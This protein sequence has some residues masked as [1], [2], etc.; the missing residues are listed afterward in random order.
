M[1]SSRCVID[2]CSRS[3]WLRELDFVCMREISL[4]SGG[5][6]TSPVIT[7]DWAVSLG[8]CQVLL[9]VSS[10]AQLS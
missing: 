7:L 1:S 5:T 9:L 10:P 3:D 4:D 6:I 8:S 2:V